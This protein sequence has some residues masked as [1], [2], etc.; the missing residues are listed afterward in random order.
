[1]DHEQFWNL[2]ET[3]HEQSKGD[4]DRQMETL[5]NLVDDLDPEEIVA[6]DRTFEGLIDEAYRWDLWAAAYIL[7]G[8]CSDDAFIDFRA[9]LVGRGRKVFEAALQDPDSLA[10][11]PF[12]EPE[13][14][15]FFEGLQYIAMEVYESQTGQELPQ[16]E[17][18][19]QDGR[20]EP[21]GNRWEETG[22]QLAEICPNL[23]RLYG[24]DDEAV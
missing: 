4:P 17:V 5:R 1:M 16:P 14:E 2:I 15:C 9:S 11:I 18:G 23:W 19:S 10:R 3:S 7:G 8:G 13:D 6:F 12:D 24:W 20:S 21:V 22:D